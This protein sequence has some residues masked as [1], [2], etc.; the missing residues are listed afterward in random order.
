MA[1]SKQITL[2]EYFYNKTAADA[3][4]VA[5]SETAGLLKN[6]GTVDTSTYLTTESATSTYL[7]KTS[8][9]TTYLS[10]TDASSTYLSKTDASSNYVAKENGK[11]LS[12]ADFTTEEKTKLAGIEAQANKTIIDSSLSAESTNPVQ[13]KVINTALGTK[14]NASDLSTVATTGAYS[15]LTGT[16]TIPTDTSDLTN[17]AGY[18]TGVDIEDLGGVV[19]VEQADEPTSGYGATYIITQ[20]GVQVGDEINIPKD[21]FVKSGTVNTVGASGAK[22]ASQLGSGYANGDKYIDFVINTA[23][24]DDTDKHMYI[25]VKDLVEDTTY[26]A[27][28][29]T[30][31][32]S[33]GTFSIKSGVIPSAGTTAPTANGTAA[34]GSATSYARADHVHPS[35]VNKA[36][37]THTHGNITNDG[38]VG[39][40]A[41]KPLI[42][43]TG[44]AVT[45]GSF[46]TT[47]GTFA[48]GNHT[49]AQ[50]I[51][52][53]QDVS[54]KLEFEDLDDIIGLS[55][56]DTT[57]ILSITLTDPNE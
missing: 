42:T 38:K 13:N 25:N 54:D 45:T 2:T 53:H 46:G 18:I 4:F 17:G 31:T 8:A 47:S 23:D 51:T 20:G 30:L 29:V 40:V 19:D 37:A 48:E 32:L 16:P 35:D 26:D 41:D 5:K 11:G 56:N 36:D 52:S 14:A 22:T 24:D 44:G 3:K 39:T 57:G 1:T 21:F 43:T 50:Y 10:K 49:H 55:Y 34:V 7:D 28:E 6:D 27:D 9:S 15:D 33:N 12:T